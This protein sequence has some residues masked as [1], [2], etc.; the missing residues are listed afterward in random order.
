MTDPRPPL[1]EMAASD[2][3]PEPLPRRRL[4]CLVTLLIVT[5][6]VV[7]EAWGLGWVL[8]RWGW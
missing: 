7:V 5:L 3:D 6:V 4:P 8:G 1:G 2:P